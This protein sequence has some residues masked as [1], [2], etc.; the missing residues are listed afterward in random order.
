MKRTRSALG[1]VALI[2]LGMGLG[3]LYMLLRTG[4]LVPEQD[5]VV[6]SVS[7][8]AVRVTLLEENGRAVEI[9][10]TEVAVDTQF[11]VYPGGLVRP[12][13]Y[14]WLGVALA[15]L[16]VRTVI[17]EMPF[18]LAVL[19]P[20]RVEGWL[21][22]SLP[23]IIGG[24][25]LGGA[26]AARYTLNHP[27]NIDGLVLLASYPAESDDLSALAIDT[28][29]LAAEH[30]GLATLGAV[31]AGLARLPN[32]DLIQIDGAVH[33]FFGRYGPQDGDGVPTVT[34]AEAEAAIVAAL[35]AYFGGF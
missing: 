15:P 24:H 20:G 13:A 33:S 11:I 19:A 30:D 29:V 18:D 8:D 2:A 21:E 1:I 7:A 32:P 14:T 27:Q 23:T 22:P 3:V 31:R 26:M 4:P 12:Q 16:G 10:P 34:R 28:L 5:A 35:R 17:V 6:A 25:S 9:L